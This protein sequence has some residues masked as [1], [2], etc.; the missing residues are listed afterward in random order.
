LY[1]ADRI[2]DVA[3]ANAKSLVSEQL[4]L[5]LDPDDKEV[6][7]AAKK[8]GIADDWIKS[9]QDSPVYKLVKR[10]KIA[11]PLH[12]EFR[13]LPMLF[14][15]PPLSPV[16][17]SFEQGFYNLPEHGLFTD[18]DNGRIPLKYLANIF[19]AGE[20]GVVETALQRLW[21]VRMYQRA[22]TVG[23]ASHEE[24]AAILTET[25]LSEGELREVFELIA[26]PRFKDR[27]VMPP[28]HR[29][30]DIEV[31]ENPL[32]HKFETGFGFNPLPGRGP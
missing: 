25:Q 24:I 9:A 16:A 12:P 23:D 30:L 5:I 2:R 19:A 22:Q 7:A 14:Y 8:N 20:S 4:S 32:K 18:A 28:Y 26:L 13:T 6:V 31:T 11:L 29:E 21:L 15:I 27:F 17:A 1:D 10:W 3:G